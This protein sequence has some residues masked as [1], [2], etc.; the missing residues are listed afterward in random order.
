MADQ[1]INE[2]K[3]LQNLKVISKEIKNADMDDLRSLADM[4]RQKTGSAV[5]VLAA[6]GK[7]GVNIV[8]VV[9]KDLVSK[10]VDAGRLIKEVAGIVGGSGG[11]RPDLAQAGGKDP[12]KL[13]EAL[14]LVYDIVKRELQ[15]RK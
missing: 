8:F 15:K 10:G 4:I 1:I 12:E 11:G 5:I 3:E 13:N 9:T 2:S 14:D 7:D 6:S